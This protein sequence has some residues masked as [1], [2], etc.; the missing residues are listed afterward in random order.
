[1]M[2]GASREA[3]QLRRERW[4]LLANLVKAAEPLMAVLG[5]V[6]L[7]M[8][9]TE[10]TVGSRPVL[11]SASNIIWAFFVVDFAAEFLIAPDKKLY[12]RRHWLVLLSLALPALRVARAA[13]VLRLGR[14][15]RSARG[16]RLLRTMTSLNR[17]MA[18]L[19]ATM[20]RR[21]FAYVAVLTAL[22]TLGG[23]AAMYAFERDVTDPVGLHDFATAL[24][25]TAMIMT[26]MG[27]AYWP[28][29]AEGRVLCV[30][31][32]LY[33]FA[34]FGYLTATIASYFVARDAER[35]DAPVASQAS[36]DA[37]REQVTALA[38]TLGSGQYQQP[39]RRHA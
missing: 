1:M 31:L 33:A 28:E 37:L 29:T 4:R 6:W 38:R 19:R 15:A 27:S 21:G 7:L 17:A 12:L 35:P 3:V 25:W 13:R 32:A 2:D 23:A 34:V 14:L 39:D 10:F 11:S 9:V 30:F 18:S 16:V 5:I 20:R 8:L 36:V 22:V 24:W 26:T